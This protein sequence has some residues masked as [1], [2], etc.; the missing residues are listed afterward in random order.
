MIGSELLEH[1]S[2]IMTIVAQEQTAVST[3]CIAGFD[4]WTTLR[5]A[6]VGSTI[7]LLFIWAGFDLIFWF[8]RGIDWVIRC[9]F[10][11]FQSKR[12]T[13]N[14]RS[15]AWV[16]RQRDRLHQ[17]IVNHRSPVLYTLLVG[18]IPTPITLTVAIGAV[19][20]LK[21][22]HGFWLIFLAGIIRTCAWVGWVYFVRGVVEMLF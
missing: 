12:E 16:D 17:K 8:S 14:S 18:S 10:P 15:K 7:G 13:R 2:W 20:I 6:L 9:L 21:I 11:R 22:K 4:V 19:R 1:W 3:M 5:C